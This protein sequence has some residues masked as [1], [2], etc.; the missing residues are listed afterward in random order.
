MSAAALEKSQKLITYT[1]GEVDSGHY[2]E[3]SNQ[4]RDTRKITI[5]EY[6]AYNFLVRRLRQDQRWLL[7]SEHRVEIVSDAILGYH[8]R[9]DQVKSSSVRKIIDRLHSL[10]I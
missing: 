10:L 3:M 6:T 1:L 7:Q 8:R 5:D 9:F 2:V 4:L